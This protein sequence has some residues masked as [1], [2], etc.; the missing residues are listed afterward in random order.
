MSSCRHFEVGALGLIAGLD[1]RFESRLDERAHAAAEHRL[2][3][4]EIGFG[5]FLECGFEHSGAGAANA[6]EVAEGERVGGAGRVLEDGDEARDA[7]ALG[8][9]FAHAMAGSLGRSHT[10]IDARG[11][12]DGL[13]VN[14]EP[15]REHAAVCRR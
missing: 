13:E 12:H 7:A 2:L 14:I 4:E 15:V 6:L 3:A 8:K 11:R 1:Q 5:L 10:Y 9:D